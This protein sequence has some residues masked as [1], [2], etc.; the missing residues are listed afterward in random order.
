MIF[1]RKQ[2]SDD[3]LKNL[4]A[5]LLRPR[6][7]EEKMLILLRQNKISK[8]FSGIGQEAVSVG[9]T[10]ALH[11]DEYIFP[12][13]RN[14]GVFTS[15]NLP[16][17]RLFSQWQGTMR[18]YTKGRD[19][20]FHFGTNEHHIVGMISHLGPQNGVADGIALGCKLKKEKKV[21]AVFNGDGG[22]SEGDFHEAI[23]VA[24]VWDLPVLFIIE[25]NGY[26]LST[27]SSEQ[28][29]CESFADK[30]IGYGM[31][32]V[33]IDG[34]NILEVYDTIHLLAENIRANPRPVLIECRT[35]RMRGH[36]EASGTKYVPKELM[37][38][39]SQKDPLENFERYLIA[40]QIIDPAFVEQA[41]K[42]IKKEID[43]GLEAAFAETEPVPQTETEVR[44]VYAPFEQQVINPVAEAQSEKRFIDAISDALRQSMDRFNDLVL[45]GQDI[46]EYGGVFKITQGLVEAYGKDRV[47]NTPL[48]ESAIVGCGLG[49]SIKG[50]K[51]MVE[52][53]FAD[54]VTEGFNQIINNL[55][56]AHWRWGQRAD[57]VIR[58]PTGAG[59]AA[60][61]YHS[62]SNEAWFFHT[63]GLKIVYP[64]NPYDAKGLLCAALEDPNPYLYFEHKFLYR[65]ISEVIPDEYY[66]VEIGK[67]RLVKDGS[68]LSIITYG[69]GV[70]W[71]LEILGEIEGVSADV[72]DLR[73]LLPWDQEAVTQ[74]VKKTNRVLIL[75][76][77][78][79]TG[80]IGAELS[81]W[82]NENLFRFLDA[83]VKRV[84][85]LDTPIPFAA[86]LE[87]N[88][89]PKG[90]LRAAIEEVMRW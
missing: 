3:L 55:A 28:F 15:R 32:A 46:A 24:A 84:A 85:S 14:L 23:N 41:R 36:E 58:M 1:N 86:S 12:M 9:L 2:Y 68:D 64:S 73:T 78:T 67:A 59:T 52:M 72:L 8:W 87:K 47:R 50:M 11:E 42:K 74:T 17:D 13:H 63:P 10:M 26:G 53:Q 5:G 54:F 29:R 69:M 40:E 37:E 18:G 83:P 6:M 79:L 27:P 82:I 48:C 90:R 38:E 7:I 61:P 80:G 31:D 25:N 30:G 88:F 71:A 16:L 89:L 33:S 22:T 19:R 45:M 34:N 66:T 44:D 20:S 56:K 4:Y 70:H 65:S 75:H 76:E 51:S 57:I 43:H 35:F 62:Q 81:A 77:D 21:T 60:G 39:W 49:L